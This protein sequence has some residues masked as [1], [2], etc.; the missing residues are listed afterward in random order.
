MKTKDEWIKEVESSLNSF[1]S[2]EVNPYLYSK[3][4]S[5]I[6]S[7]KGEYAPVKL[8]WVTAL[9]I[10]ALIFL[11]ITVLNNTQSPLKNNYVE[12]QIVADQYKLANN[13][14]INYN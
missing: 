12:V 5:R 9:S 4:L 2:D 14:L 1:K 10:T 13:S 7:K 6:D 11:N 8:V 3:I